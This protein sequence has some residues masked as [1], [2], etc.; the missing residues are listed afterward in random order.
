VAFA[1]QSRARLDSHGAPS[2]I[3]DDELFGAEWRAA[4]GAAGVVLSAGRRVVPFRGTCRG[5][6]DRILPDEDEETAMTNA[7]PV[8]WPR[9]GLRTIGV[10]LLALALAIGA[11]P[12][13]ADAADDP[14]AF[15]QGIGD[16]VVEILQQ[17]LPREQAEQQLNAVWLGAFDVEG[18]GKAVLGKNWK[19]ATETQRQDYMQVFPHYVA[20]LYA[21]QFS[22]YSGETFAVNGSKAGTAGDAIVNAQI[23][24]PGEEP[25]RV[26]FVL[27]PGGQGLKIKD[28][29]VEGVSLLVT[30][31]SEFDSVIA[32]KG[33]DGLIQAMRDKVGQV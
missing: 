18:I 31:R 7:I 27:R 14:Q 10:L 28:V 22:D 24:R 32:Q 5:D 17:N 23:D 19:K 1:P 3:S 16:K 2:L 9:S 30:K 8:R 12:R 6:A 21:I 15:V 4:C 20:K 25:V 26:D 13:G 29:K 11:T 33:I